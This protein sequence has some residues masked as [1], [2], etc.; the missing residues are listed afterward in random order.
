MLTKTLTVLTFRFHYRSL[1]HAR[2]YSLCGLIYTGFVIAVFPIRYNNNPY[3]SE[4]VNHYSTNEKLGSWIYC[5]SSRR[6]CGGLYLGSQRTRWNGVWKMPTNSWLSIT[7]LSL[8]P[9]AAS[10]RILDNSGMYCT[11]LYAASKSLF[12]FLHRAKQRNCH[13]FL[14]LFR[15]C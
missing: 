4:I 10:Q 8:Q 6:K 15:G 5:I 11:V 2:T 7:N 12:C 13:L 9:F 1:T 14:L 3:A